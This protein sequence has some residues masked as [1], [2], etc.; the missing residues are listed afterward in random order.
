MQVTRGSFTKIS[1]EELFFH[2]A[3]NIMEEIETEFKMNHL[4]ISS[5]CPIIKVMLL[6]KS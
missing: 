1:K 5:W 6:L 4:L 3:S 2:F